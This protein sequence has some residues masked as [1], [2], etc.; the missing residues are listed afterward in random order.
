ME[1]KLKSQ[2]SSEPTSCRYTTDTLSPPYHR[3][4]EQFSS[5]EGLGQ[6]RLKLTVLK[7]LLE[8]PAL[9]P[10]TILSCSKGSGFEQGFP[11]FLPLFCSLMVLGF[12]Y[13]CQWLVSLSAF[14]FQCEEVSTTV[15]D[16]TEHFCWA[17]P[18]LFPRDYLAC[19]NIW[20]LGDLGIFL[21]THLVGKQTF[22][23]N[24]L[25]AKVKH[26]RVLKTF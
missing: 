19:Q 11:T 26:F 24:Y 13:S 16:I 25:R 15:C 7:F 8:N 20:R 5:L 12:F 4:K 6:H 18:H 14:S 2:A 1:S 22:T 17:N 23:C 3:E 10:R 9:L 21:K